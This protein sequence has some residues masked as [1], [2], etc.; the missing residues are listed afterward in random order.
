M[1]Y[2]GI[3]VAKDTHFSAVKDSY[4]VVLLEP[5]SFSNYAVGFSKL[6]K[7]FRRLTN[8]NYLSIL[9]LQA[10]ILKTSLLSFTK[11]PILLLLSRALCKSVTTLSL[12][13]PVS[14]MLTV[15]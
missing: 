6:T 7:N 10:F 9:N 1:I 4:G 15:L 2:V 8:Q 14:V 5:I 3:D 11:M 13:S 12:L